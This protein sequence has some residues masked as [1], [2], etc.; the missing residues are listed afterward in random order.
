VPAYVPSLTERADYYDLSAAA[1]HGRFLPDVSAEALEEILG[2][3]E[4]DL[5]SRARLLGYYYKQKSTSASKLRRIADQRTNHILWFIEHACDCKFAGDL[6]LAMSKNQFADH[7]RSI[8]KA[9]LR[10]IRAHKDH[11]QTTI[12]AAMFT[13]KEEP[14]VSIELLNSGMRKHRSNPWVNALLRKLDQPALALSDMIHQV[15]T[16]DGFDHEK[17]RLHANKLYLHNMLWHGTS[18]P[19]LSA[20]TLETVVS[21]YPFDLN[22][23]AELVGHYHERWKRNNILGFD[24]DALA[25]LTRHILWFIE[26]TPGAEHMTEWRGRLSERKRAPE[27]HAL[28][29]QAWLRAVDS[30][31]K[32][33]AVLATA[34]AFF[35]EYGDRRCATALLKR[36]SKLNSKDKD[37]AEI[38]KYGVS[39]SR[40]KFP[41]EKVTKEQEDAL[42]HVAVK[43]ASKLSR[44]P[45]GKYSFAEWAS[46]IDLC[47]A[48]LAG[49]YHWVPPESIA[50]LEAVLPRDSFDIYNRAKAI[51]SYDKYYT[52]AD[53]SAHYHQVYLRDK[54]FKDPD[55]LVTDKQRAAYLEH[56]DWFVRHLPESRFVA[57]FR[58]NILQKRDEES[59][60][61]IKDLYLKQA[62]DDSAKLDALINVAVAFYDCEKEVSSDLAK[63]IARKSPA[64]A[65]RVRLL[66]G[67]KAAQVDVDTALNNHQFKDGKRDA[68]LSAASKAIDL[69][70]RMIDLR[71]LAPRSIWSH[72]RALERNPNDTLLRGAALEA[73]AALDQFDVNF[74]GHTPDVAPDLLRHC[75]WFI[76]HIPDYHLYS[77][78]CQLNLRSMPRRQYLGP[79]AILLE[80]AE[81]QMNAYPKSLT[82][83]LGLGMYYV[84][85]L[86]SEYVSRLKKMQKLHPKNQSLASQLRHKL[87]LLERRTPGLYEFRDYV[88]LSTKKSGKTKPKTKR[89]GV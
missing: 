64:W 29:A 42:N 33:P 58:V 9:W 56:M 23:R 88:S 43:C 59:Y 24:A 32:N 30:F 74:G 18:M 37:V 39:D 34:A 73:Y 35:F 55:V 86:E 1:E 77:L 79:Q 40:R 52:D 19:P 89:R 10:Q 65:E 12:N 38:L 15:A 76:Q 54:S 14:S 57:T 87:S 16:P 84:L 47:G 27:H 41:K 49:V 26:H 80:A 6:Y 72:E 83:C 60:L 3:N 70:R 11:V 13:F 22:A 82:V 53:A 36:V 62:N 7:Y 63:I 48:H 46:E 28:L 61:R 66:L 67:R 17:W 75:L 45:F 51:G 85:G 5:Y 78:G 2:V 71:R 25:Q 4:E 21:T 8:K 50:N 44:C 20:H 69:T 81:R 68:R 31:P